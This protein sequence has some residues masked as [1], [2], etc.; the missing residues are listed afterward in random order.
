MAQSHGKSLSL[1][2]ITVKEPGKR[3]PTASAATTL[4]RSHVNTVHPKELSKEPSPILSEGS[5]GSPTS[6]TSSLMALNTTHNGV[7]NG[8]FSVPLPSLSLQKDE[9]SSSD[10]CIDKSSS[11]PPRIYP[12]TEISNRD[13]SPEVHHE[14]TLSDIT[15]TD[16]E[17]T[18]H[19]RAASTDG[20]LQCMSPD[21]YL[22]DDYVQL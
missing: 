20:L 17:L 14:R 13:R 12:F 6:I 10:R 21:D 8:G 7:T 4:S 11:P 19:E 16:R 1:R 18:R 3:P 2:Y 9:L 5:T 22:S 15:K